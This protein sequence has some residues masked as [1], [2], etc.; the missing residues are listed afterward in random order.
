[1]SDKPRALELADGHEICGQLYTAHELRRL[2]GQ[3]RELREALTC[4][5]RDAISAGWLKKGRYAGVMDM[6]SIALDNTKDAD[7][8]APEEDSD[9]DP[10]TGLRKRSPDYFG[11]YD[12]EDD[13]SHLMGG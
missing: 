5:R 13:T 2:V 10:D 9:T 3:V 11:P 12:E 4:L 6:A 8:P 1:M 7:P